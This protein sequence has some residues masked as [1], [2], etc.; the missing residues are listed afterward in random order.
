M[1]LVLGFFITRNEL[2]D[3]FI[4]YFDHRTSFRADTDF[5]VKNL[6]GIYQIEYS[7]GAGESGGISNPAY[8]AKLDEFAAWYRRQPGVMHVNTLSDTMK[9]L[10]MNLHGDAPQWRRLPDNRELAAQ[11]LLLYELSLPY[12]L[13]LNNQISVDKSATRFTVS[14]KNISAR[15]MREIEAA[16]EG[17]LRKHAPAAMFTHGASSAVMFVHI[18]LR[19]IQSMLTGTILEFLLIAGA[20]VFALRSVKFG[21]LSLI[22]N[23]IPAVLGF[24]VWGM[25]VGRVGLGLSVVTSMTLG[26][27]IDDTVHYLSKYLR[28]R[29]EKGLSTEEAIRYAFSSTGTAMVAASGILIV[30]FLVLSLS[31][32][33]LNADMGKLTAITIA[34]ALPGD[35]LFLPAFLMKLD[36]EK[37]RVRVEETEMNS[38]L[39]RKE[40]LYHEQELYVAD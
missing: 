22:P 26:I 12:G 27:V 31:T 20:L 15:E 19:N 18:T 35:L 10:N 28:A 13:D 40:E 39:P 2:N 14:F 23:I 37:P 9:R 38:L 24:G 3:S 16:A 21:V 25:M 32:F 33:E 29:R 6:T 4:N 30:G 36:G 5:T 7:L 1:V 34:L 11:Y 8:L 17:W